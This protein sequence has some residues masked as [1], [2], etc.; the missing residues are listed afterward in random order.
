MRTS[1]SRNKHVAKISCN[2][3][4][5]SIFTVFRIVMY[6]NLLVGHLLPEPLARETGRPLPMALTIY[7]KLLTYSVLTLNPGW[8]YSMNLWVGVY[9]WDSETL[10]L[11]TRPYLDAFCNPTCILHCKY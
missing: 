2:K 11:Y 9:H 4:V 8:G 7:I 10:N 1:K 3:V 5:K 6:L